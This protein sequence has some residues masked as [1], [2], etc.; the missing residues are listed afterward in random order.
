M[1]QVTAKGEATLVVDIE[2]WCAKCGDGICSHYRERPRRE[3]VFDAEPCEACLERAKE[4]GQEAGRD[5][6]QGEI[7]ELKERVE[8]LERKLM[9]AENVA[10]AIGA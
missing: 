10:K 5:E 7:D 2:F 4:E 3:G 9:D 1:P 6:R 8:E